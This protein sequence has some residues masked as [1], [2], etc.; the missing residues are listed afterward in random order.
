MKKLFFTLAVYGFIGS[1]S[2]IP[3][4]E[5]NE[6]LSTPPRHAP[7][8]GPAIDEAFEWVEGVSLFTGEQIFLQ[9]LNLPNNTPSIAV[10]S[11]AGVWELPTQIQANQ[12][13][14][15]AIPD[16]NNIPDQGALGSSEGESLFGSARRNPFPPENNSEGK[17]RRL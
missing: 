9:I 5:V 12:P 14:A 8:P 10:G 3:P 7:S 13:A 1:V 2:A 4:Q 15:A 6:G 16:A 17:R 11:P